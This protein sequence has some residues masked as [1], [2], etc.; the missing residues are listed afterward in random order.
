MRALLLSLLLLLSGCVNDK[1]LSKPAVK[2]TPTPLAMV[3]FYVCTE[4]RGIWITMSDG[5]SQAFLEN[6][7]EGD[8]ILQALIEVM[9]PARLYVANAQDCTI[10][11]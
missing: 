5:T 9:Q 10:P 4:R 1:T 3:A 11:T 2:P 8:P 7:I 6:E